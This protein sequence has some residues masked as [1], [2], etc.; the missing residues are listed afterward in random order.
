M[1]NVIDLE[2]VMRNGAELNQF[3]MDNLVTLESMTNIIS[4]HWH[5][6]NNQKRIKAMLCA[7]EQLE[8]DIQEEINNEF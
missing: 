6:T 7:L 8:K 3:L 4:L 5:A 1:K 2:H